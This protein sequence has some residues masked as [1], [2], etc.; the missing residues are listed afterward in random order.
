MA[1]HRGH[2]EVCRLLVKS[3]AELNTVPSGLHCAASGGHLECVKFFL[4]VPGLDTKC[5][6]MGRGTALSMAAKQGHVEVVEVQHKPLN[7]RKL[8]LRPTVKDI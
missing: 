8:L 4:N 2:I 1:A 7:K 5:S 3:G 6:V